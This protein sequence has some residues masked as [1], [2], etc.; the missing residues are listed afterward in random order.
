MPKP[1]PLTGPRR[2]PAGM[3][4]AV[5]IEHRLFRALAILRVVVTI[6][7][8][9]INA[10]RAD[11]YDHPTAGLLVVVTLVVWTG[12]AL[13]LYDAHPRRTAWLLVAD[14]AI[15][16][17]AMGLTPW[18]KT[19]DFNATIPGFWVMGALLAWAIHWHWKGG[20]VAAAVLSVADLAFRNSLDQANYGNVFLL[21]IG[22]P[23]VGYM[24]ESLQRMAAERDAAQRA[25][26]AAEERTRL[27]RAVHDGVLQVLAMVQRQ[28]ASAGGE[29]TRL[30]ALAGEQE[31]SLRSLI[32]Q[33]DTVTA[34]PGGTADLAGALE[35][36]GTSHPVRV[37]VANPGGAVLL[38]A[39][40]VEEIVAVVS[41]CLDNVHSHVG[42]DATAWVLLEATPSA[43]TV[44]VRDDGDG[45]PEGRLEAAASD[46][47][48]GVAS[49]IRG[50][51]AELGGTAT[52]DT[53][54]WGTAW[55]F[56]VPR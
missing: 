13:W 3:D 8:V 48:L 51:V 11:N 2:D 26:V 20:L 41:A 24:C 19:P 37:E 49:S 12:V 40:R 4:S 15:A 27:A 1:A 35:A 22:G 6:N 18:V 45:I 14:L 29:W 46:G 44:S 28:G 34:Q 54:E 38:D 23:I 7:M 56:E 36:L 9:A 33:Q 42:A 16:A 47:R 25:A 39:H 55:E 21:M 52:L 30:G 31:R 10:Y 32:R 17:I 43:V 53:G 5:A 50:R